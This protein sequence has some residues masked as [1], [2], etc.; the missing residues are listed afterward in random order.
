MKSDNFRWATPSNVLA[1]ESKAECAEPWIVCTR[2][3]SSNIFVDRTERTHDERFKRSIT[4]ISCG[5]M[6]TQVGG[7]IQ[8]RKQRVSPR[9]TDDEVKKIL[10]ET[11]VSHAAMGR[12]MSRSR[13]FIRQVRSGIL[14]ID[15]HA[16]IPRWPKNKESRRCTK[17]IYWTGV[18]CQIGFQDPIKEGVRFAKDCEHFAEIEK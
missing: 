2:C 9:L 15:V 6:W 17:C 12:K 4:C 3:E 7:R 10:L 18:K 1:T 11:G 14:Y 13:E 5:N 16:E 8:R